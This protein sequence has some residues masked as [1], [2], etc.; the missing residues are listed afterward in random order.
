[1]GVWIGFNGDDRRVEI[2]GK[3]SVVSSRSTSEPTFEHLCLLLP[4]ERYA[5]PTSR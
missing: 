5:I 2:V 4:S 3:Q 1:M